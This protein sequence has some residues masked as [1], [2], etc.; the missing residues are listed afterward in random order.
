MAKRKT[1]RK[2]IKSKYN[3]LGRRKRG[4]C[5][6]ANGRWFL[7]NGQS[8]PN[9]RLVHGEVMGYGELKGLQ[10]S[11]CWIEDDM[12]VLD[13]SKKHGPDGLC[14]P[15]FV[16]Y[17]VGH[18]DSIDNM[19]KYDRDTF[20]DRINQTGHWGAWDLRMLRGNKK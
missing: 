17:A 10:H 15:K 7:N 14:V 20:L 6:E 2:K 11:H 16:Y 9:L 19:I 18:I 4:D 5:F 12:F 8:R 1:K 13:F 3:H